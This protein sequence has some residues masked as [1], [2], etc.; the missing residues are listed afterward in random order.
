MITRDREFSSSLG[1]SS[2]GYRDWAL[3]LPESRGW[4]EKWRRGGERESLDGQ[5]DKIV[6]CIDSL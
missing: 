2:S 4:K 5:T 6:F 3:F 1:H